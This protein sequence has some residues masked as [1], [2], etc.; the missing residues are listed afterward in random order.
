MPREKVSDEEILQVRRLRSDGRDLGDIS[1]Q[2][3]LSIGA[4]H[5]YSVDIKPRKTELETVSDD[6]PAD[7]KTKV[8]QVQARAMIEKEATAIL[9]EKI[10]QSNLRGFCSVSWNELEEYLSLA[11][12]LGKN[13]A[14]DE[15]LV[16]LSESIKD[17]KRS[18]EAIQQWIDT[19]ED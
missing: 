12:K 1:R 7:L 9:R 11:L 19:L 3:G 8:S 16:Q 10:E 15:I 2:T 18:I 5:K 17:Q 13:V 6:L 14:A 4:C